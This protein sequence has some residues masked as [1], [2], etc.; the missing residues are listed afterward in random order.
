MASRSNES[1]SLLKEST[2]NHGVFAIRLPREN[3]YEETNTV[4]KI[5]YGSWL[6][7]LKGNSKVAIVSTGPV[8][9][10]LKEMLINSQKDVTLYNAIYLRPMD[11]NKIK[12][13]LEY[14]KIIIYNAYATKEGFANALEARLIELGYKGNIIVKTVP[15]VYVKQ[16]SILQ[17]RE[18]FK[19]TPKD[20]LELL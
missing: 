8:T 6:T 7:E 15:D 12:E 10:E 1:L 3:I 14:E 19:I 13:L 20:I 4:H 2:C 5:P 18:E 11:E 17:Q 9:L 16:A